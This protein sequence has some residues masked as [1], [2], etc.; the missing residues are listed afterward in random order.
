MPPQ[1]WDALGR[2]GPYTA[3]AFLVLLAIYKVILPAAIRLVEKAWDHQSATED[4]QREMLFEQFKSLEQ[5]RKDDNERHLLA[6]EKRDQD[7]KEM[8][9][10]HEAALRERDNLNRE[11]HR[12]QM[13][14]MAAVA[15]KIE[16]LTEQLH[17]NKNSGGN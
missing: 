1:A 17:N 13:A 14:G 2:Y 3:L 16:G 12:E 4:K 15:A 11:I 9:I 10:R 8:L 5:A 7:V 6:I